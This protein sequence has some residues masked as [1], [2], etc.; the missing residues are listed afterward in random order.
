MTEL[1]NLETQH[2]HD[3]K[4]ERLRDSLLLMRADLQAILHEET[5][6]ALFQLRKKH[7]EAGDKSGKMPAL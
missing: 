3:P 2:M 4:N 6:F 7:F 1:K 5:S